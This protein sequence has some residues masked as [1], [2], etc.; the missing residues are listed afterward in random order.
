MELCHHDGISNDGSRIQLVF[1]SPSFCAKERQGKLSLKV[2]IH[3]PVIEKFILC[4]LKSVARRDV[5]NT[6]R[7]P[8]VTY[9]K[10]T[11]ADFHYFYLKG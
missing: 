7:K 2:V 8:S 4:L 11:S 3:I 10:I 6:N 5:T 9:E 1:P